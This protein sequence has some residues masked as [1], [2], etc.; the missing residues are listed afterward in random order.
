MSGGQCFSHHA[1]ADQ[2][3]CNKGM[4]D[5][6]DALVKESNFSTNQFMSPGVGLCSLGTKNMNIP[7]QHPSLSSHFAVWPDNN[8]SCYSSV[9]LQPSQNTVPPNHFGS[10]VGVSSPNCN[11]TVCMNSGSQSW[12]TNQPSPHQAF[13]GFV[14]YPS[15]NLASNHEAYLSQVQSQLTAIHLGKSS[16]NS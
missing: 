16:L 9:P 13:G 10:F 14:T 7:S 5:L 11:S 2:T 15:N 12:S 3:L 6:G 4:G 1:P 8:T